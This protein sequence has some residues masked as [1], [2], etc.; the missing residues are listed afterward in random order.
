MLNLIPYKPGFESPFPASRVFARLLLEYEAHPL[1][2]AWIPLL[3]LNARLHTEA[4]ALPHPVAW[5]SLG[6]TEKVRHFVDKAMQRTGS[7]ELEVE[8]PPSL[9]AS[10]LGAAATAQLPP[11]LIESLQT[12][13][14]AANPV[15]AILTTTLPPFCYEEFGGTIV[16][17]TP[18]LSRQLMQSDIARDLPHCMFRLP[19]KAQYVPFSPELQTQLSTTRD[20]LGAYV[21]ELPVP[22]TMTERSGR[23]LEF[24]I[25]ETRVSQGLPVVSMSCLGLH[26]SPELENQPLMARILTKP[27]MDVRDQRDS[28][29]PS[30]QGEPSDKKLVTEF[31]IESGPVIDYLFK[32]FL[33]MGMRDSVR[34]D[35]T[36]QAAALAD[37]QAQSRHKRAKAFRHALR[38]YDRIIVGPSSALSPPAPVS[39]GTHKTMH[40]RRGHFRHQRCGTGFSE[41]KV[42]FIEPTLIRQDLLT[43]GTP[44]PEKKTYLVQ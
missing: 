13:S 36:Q 42:I 28:E 22:V 29:A 35:I 19:F 17:P 6:G 44:A 14:R 27:A 10:G 25:V 43:G 4:L 1:V 30:S 7:N 32:L 5:K 18:A 2:T 9:L 16:E 15:P 31:Q 3:I 24:H 11:A 38:K 37:A 8:W 41:S 12:T 23:F 33:Y 21:F 34:Q 20:W 39:T 40:W 26:I